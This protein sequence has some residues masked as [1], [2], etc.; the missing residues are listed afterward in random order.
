MLHHWQE[1]GDLFNYYGHTS[2]FSGTVQDVLR[3]EAQYA[4]HPNNIPYIIKNYFEWRAQGAS[5]GPFDLA[6]IRQN[7]VHT[8]YVPDGGVNGWGYPNIL[9]YNDVYYIVNGYGGRAML[10]EVGTQRPW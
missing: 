2:H 9:K 8:Y 1:S 4:G 6:N 7:D 10:L 5:G 3:N